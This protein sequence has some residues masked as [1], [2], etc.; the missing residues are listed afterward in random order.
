MGALGYV[1]ARSFCVG[2]KKAIDLNE[3]NYVAALVLGRIYLYEG[4]YDIG[5]HYLRSALRLNPNDTDTL[6]QLASCFVFLGHLDEA[7]TLYHKV[8]QLNPLKVRNYYHVGCLIAFEK[9]QF[10]KAITLGLSANSPWVDSP[11]MIAAAYYEMG[12]LDNM[13]KWWQI[14]L[15]EFQKKIVRLNSNLIR[16]K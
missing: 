8:L 4:E 11:G 13:R 1:P 7:E 15:Q 9:G 6:I 2:K 12:D 3:Q 14:Y 5:E 16:K 10:E